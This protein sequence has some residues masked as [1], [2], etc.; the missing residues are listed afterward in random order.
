[1]TTSIDDFFMFG[2]GRCNKHATPECKVNSWKVELQLLRNI[3]LKTNLVETIKWGMPCYQYNSK[4]VLMIAPFKDNCV[5]SFFKGSLL[6]NNQQ[7]L[8]KAGENSAQAR[9]IRFKNKADILK[10]EHEI[11]DLILESIEVEKKGLKTS[12]TMVSEK[13]YP[14]EFSHKLDE[15]GSLKK[16]FK[17][18]TPGKQRA[19]LIYFNSAK[20]V[21]TRETRINK[22]IPLILAGKGL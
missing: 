21:A 7:L 2:C 20:Q 13:D 18:L 9:V 8:T 3:V 19:Y 1:M 12:P 4:N 6:K 14:I 15:S 10:N 17:E 16:A 5:I 11:L 22:C